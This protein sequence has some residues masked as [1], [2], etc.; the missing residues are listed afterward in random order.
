MNRFFAIL[1][2]FVA[3]ALI[4]QDFVD[5][6]G[7]RMSYTIVF[8]EGSEKRRVRLGDFSI[9]ATETTVGEWQEFLDLTGYDFCR[10]KHFC[11]D[12][13]RWSP[14]DDCPIQMVRIEDAVAYCNWK[15]ERE[16][17]TPVYY[18][19]D[20]RI[21][22]NPEA[23]GY[24]L[25]TVDEW[26]YAARGGRKSRNYRYSGSD[27]PDEVAWYGLLAFEGT[28]PVGTKK[29]NELGIYDMSGNIREWTWPEEGIP[30][31]DSEY[32][33]EVAEAKGGEWTKDEAYLAL[34]KGSRVS[35]RNYE[36]MG[37]RLAR[38]AE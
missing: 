15:S 1:V 13:V 20:G 23:D 36:H 38:N 21:L 19:R 25:P 7:G 4:A 34:S 35:V 12:I 10:E 8:D 11:G 31:P 17:L 28:R 33:W 26:D 6:K 9:A 5:V 30:T 14:E 18:N 2:F 24:R 3:T 22:R 37:F 29:P 16:H 32:E 27:N